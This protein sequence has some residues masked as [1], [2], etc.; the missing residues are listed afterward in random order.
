M[1]SICSDDKKIYLF[2]AYPHQK[3]KVSILQSSA[4]ERVDALLKVCIEVAVRISAETSAILV[5]VSVGHCQSVYANAHAEAPRLQNHFK[6]F[7]F[8]LAVVFLT[9]TLHVF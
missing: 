3:L 8:Y 9:T 6:T 5:D 1:E 7:P 4:T 2:T